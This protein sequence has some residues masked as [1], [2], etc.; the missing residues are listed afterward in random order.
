MLMRGE[1]A[2]VNVIVTAEISL[3]YHDIILSLICFDDIQA[4]WPLLRFI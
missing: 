1:I 3:R 4:L 2:G